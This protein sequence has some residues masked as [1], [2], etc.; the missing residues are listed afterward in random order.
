MPHT[1]YDVE[2]AHACMDAAVR[3]LL[4][5]ASEEKSLCDSYRAAGRAKDVW[6][7][8]GGEKGPMMG[9][10]ISARLKREFDEFASPTGKWYEREL[11]RLVDPKVSV[12]A[13]SMW[14]NQSEAASSS[15]T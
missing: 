15:R 11:A 5:R 10:Q 6:H 7:K 8:L 4:K 14:E 9:L 13:L 1:N 12:E 3:R 2:I